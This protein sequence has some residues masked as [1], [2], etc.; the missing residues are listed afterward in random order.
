MFLFDL[1]LLRRLGSRDSAPGV[2]TGYRLNG[3]GVG[4]R[5]TVGAR[6]SPLHVI[7]TGPGPY[8]ASHPV[9]TG[10]S[11]LGGRTAGA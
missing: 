5:V 2:T 3:L 10:G 9:A 8:T 4:D 6:F 1:I 11:F 7:Q